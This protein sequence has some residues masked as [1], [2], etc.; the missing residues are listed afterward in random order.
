[1][2][3]LSAQV[4]QDGSCSHLRSENAVD[5][6]AMPPLDRVDLAQVISELRQDRGK[7]RK[8]LPG[9][10]ALYESV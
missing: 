9:T 3:L 4:F 7:S 2:C 1:M 6:Y 8:P 10:L 5:L